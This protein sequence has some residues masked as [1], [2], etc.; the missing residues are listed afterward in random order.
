MSLI[1]FKKFKRK[2]DRDDLVPIPIDTFL[3]AAHDDALGLK[4][5]DDHKVNH[6][7]LYAQVSDPTN[8]K[9][10]SVR[11]DMRTSNDV[12]KMSNDC[13]QG[14]LFV[15]ALAY[16]CSKEVVKKFEVK[17]I[18]EVTVG[19]ILS[20]IS[21]NH[22]HAYDF[23]PT[24]IGCRFWVKKTLELLANNGL[25]DADDTLQ[26]IEGMKSSYG[27]KVKKNLS[28]DFPSLLAGFIFVST[29]IRFNCF[30]RFAT[31]IRRRATSLMAG[32]F[33]IATRGA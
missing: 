20:L 15:E 2:V 24:N 6:W 31:S 1:E 3:V 14:K 9:I 8:Q 12:G 27:M 29:K 19:E 13:L 23:H 4:Y 26:A 10:K 16:A 33:R 30:S 18:K 17:F 22:Y 25:V 5:G 32:K 21:E 11:Y 28:R 7:A